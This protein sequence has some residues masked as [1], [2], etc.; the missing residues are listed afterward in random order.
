MPDLPEPATQPNHVSGEHP[1]VPGA[2]CPQNAQVAKKGWVTAYAR[3]WGL[4]LAGSVIG[5][6]VGVSWV[7]VSSSAAAG[8]SRLAA[9]E[10]RQAE[11]RATFLRRL[12]L[13]DTR[14]SRTAEDAAATRAVVERSLGPL[15]PAIRDPVP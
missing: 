12:E 1:C 2:G 15:V 10:Q 3:K 14:L 8:A 5:V 11:D 9:V 4:P 7:L 13:F 6:C